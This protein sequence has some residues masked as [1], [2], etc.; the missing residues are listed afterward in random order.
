[1]FEKILY[2]TDFSDVSRKAIEYIAKLKDAGTREVVV[3]HVID[4]K[5]DCIEKLPTNLKAEL[6]RELKKEATKELEHIKSELEQ[7]DFAIKLRIEIGKPF[8]EIL[9]AEKEENVSAIVLGSHGKSNIKE[10]FLGSVSEHI[11]RKSRT[12]VLV[13]KR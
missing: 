1:M 11:I 5:A 6:Q 7:S 4:W 12:P 9:K 2:P 3:M 8:Q 13:I 10:V